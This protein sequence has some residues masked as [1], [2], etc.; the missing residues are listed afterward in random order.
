MQYKTDND[1]CIRLY[2]NMALQ[3]I[4]DA[5]HTVIRDALKEAKII[6]EKMRVRD[7]DLANFDETRPVYLAQY[8]A[9]FAV[10]EIRTDDNGLADITMLKLKY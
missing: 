6:T 10:L 5:K 1:G 9:Y 8:S 2:F 7:V 3:N 4:I